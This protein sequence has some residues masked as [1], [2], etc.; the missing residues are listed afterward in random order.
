MARL[1]KSVQ[2]QLISCNIV[3]VFNDGTTYTKSVS[4]GDIIEGLRYVYKQEVLTVTGKITAINMTC[5]KVTPVDRSN[6]ED[7]FAKDIRVST[8]VIDA[9][10]QYASKVV[11]VDAMEIV[12]DEGVENVKMVYVTATPDITL[13][14]TYTDGRVVHQ[15]IV[16]GDVLCDMDIM[17]AP[18]KP[19]ITGDFR[20]SAFNYSFFNKKLIFTG[21]YLSPL[22]GGSA[23]S[24]SFENIISFE[25]RPYSEITETDSLSSVAAALETEDEVFAFFNTDVTIPARDDGRITSLFINSGKKLTVDLAGHDLSTQAY[26][27]YV[28]GGELVIRDTKGKGAITAT[29]P[30]VAY[31]AVFVAAG[32]VCTMESGVI[33][34][35]Q[36]VLEEGDYNWLYGVACSG[37]GIFNMTGGKMIVQD[38]AGVA[39]TNGTAT[40]EGAQFNIS[41]TATITAVDCT[42]IYLAD[43]KSVNVSGNAKING[44]VLLRMGDLNVSEKAIING[45]SASADVYPLGKLVCESGCE[46]HNAAILA[47]TGCYGSALGNDLNI[48][49]SGD[50]KVN[51]YKDNAIDIATLNTKYNQVVNVNVERSS[52]ISFTNK[53]WNIFDHATLAGM[54]TA[55][56][57]TLAPETTTTTLTINVDGY[58]QYPES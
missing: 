1:V 10:E 14:M 4:V 52:N 37:D 45:V 27:F 8:L 39:I 13:E 44:G 11:T 35:T 40:G 38:A 21:M 48:N 53:L 54:A 31:P 32:G 25:E 34:T 18:Q 36:A 30:N 22:A 12:E 29:K 57:K 2:D 49:I 17:T 9:S 24:A 58:K 47:M 56:G 46:N 20:V 50:A 16:I 51:G 43:N 33:D 23:I 3:T 7:Y 26:A 5:D 55:Q 28:N 19:D 42:A 15:D 41:G 6:P